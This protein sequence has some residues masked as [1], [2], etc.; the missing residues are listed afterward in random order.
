[1]NQKSLPDDDSVGLDRATMEHMLALGGPA[2]RPALIAQLIADLDRLRAAL[3]SDAPAALKRAAHEL[4]GL[5]ATI[6]AGGLAENAG[7]LDD[8]AESA[9]PAVGQ[10]LALGIRPQIDRLAEILATQTRTA[11]A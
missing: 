10:A 6:G 11:G 4:K 9:P 8:L 7:R 2:L 3:T 1:M 5:A